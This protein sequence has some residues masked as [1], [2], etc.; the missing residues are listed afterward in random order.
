MGSVHNKL[1]AAFAA[2]EADTGIKFDLGRFTYTDNE[3]RGKL[4]ATIKNADGTTPTVAVPEWL[5]VVSRIIFQGDTFEITG[6]NTHRMKYPV[7]ARR[8][9]D[10]REF[11]LPRTAVRG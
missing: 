10:G 2:I 6:Y 7:L 5:N 9:R 3:F 8:L 1:K 4:T 11:A